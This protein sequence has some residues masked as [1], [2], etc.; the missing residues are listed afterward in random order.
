MLFDFN[1]YCPH[2]EPFMPACPHT[3]HALF[4]MPVVAKS[5]LVHLWY[6]FICN[7]F[8]LFHFMLACL[9]AHT[10]IYTPTPPH[11]ARTL[12]H[13]CL[14]THLLACTPPLAR[15]PM[16]SVPLG[17][18]PPHMI[19]NSIGQQAPQSPTG[20]NVRLIEDGK[21][22]DLFVVSLHQRLKGRMMIKGCEAMKSNDNGQCDLQAGSPTQLFCFH[23]K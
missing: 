21:V 11:H 22:F 10:H 12:V 9:H 13:A 5:S 16:R 3:L 20:P 15:P 23:S 6:I 18:F 4:H 14:P 8:F 1:I 2:L 19:T 7:T 17:D